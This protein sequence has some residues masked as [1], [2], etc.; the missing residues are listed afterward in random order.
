MVLVRRPR[1]S[2]LASFVVAFIG[3]AAFV[4]DAAPQISDSSAVT[5]KAALTA[6]KTPLTINKVAQPIVVDGDLSDL[7]WQGLSEVSTWYETNVG[8]NAV[9][10]VKNQAWLGFDEKFFYAAFRFEDPNPAGVRAPIGDHDAVSSSTDYAGIIVDSRNDGK[11]AQMF[12]ANLRGV[13]Y[14]AVSNDATGEDN[15]PDYYWD[16]KGKR[17]ATGWDL[18]IRVPFS[19][20][21]YSGTDAQTWRI[22]LYR[23]YP[24]DRRYQFFS[25]RLPKDSNCF[26]CN[27]APLEGLRDFPAGSH[28]IVAPFVTASQ[29]H[30]P[31]AGLGTGLEAEDLDPE[32][33]VDVKWNPAAT[34]AIDLTVNPDFSQL[35]SDVAQ[36]AANER[37]A[38]FFP[39]KRPFFLEGVDLFSTPQQAVYT[40]TITSPSGGLRGT[41]KVGNTAYTALVTQDQ[42]GGLVILPG[43]QSSDFALQDFESTVGVFRV[44]QDVGKSFVSALFTERKIDGGGHN[45]VVGPDFQWRPKQTDALTGQLLWSDSHTPNRPDLAAEWDGR[46]LSDHAARLDW[47]H[48]TRTL[49]WFLLGM[50]VGSDFRA[51]NGFIPQVGYQEALLDGGYTFRNPDG[52]VNRLRLFTVDWLDA[53]HDGD[54]LN[55]RVSAGLGANAK[56]NSFFRLELNNDDIRVGDELLHRFRPRTRLEMSPG[57]VVNF[58]FADAYFG[59]EIDFD[60][61]REGTGVSLTGGLSLRPTEHLELRF[62]GSRRWLDVDD[63]T[64]GAGRLFTAQVERLRTTYSFTALSFVRLIGQYVQTERDP[65]LYTFAVSEKTAAFDF[66]ALFAYKLNWQTVF[67]AGYGDRN[68]YLTTSD[69]LEPASRQFF[70]KASYA[71]QR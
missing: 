13:Q 3:S 18:E 17:T 4:G 12:L 65:S 43:P 50:D 19:S 62:D 48:Q 60:N 52:F 37:F 33:G 59:D 39:E 47:Y 69:E 5:P 14:D 31:S 21:R 45:L 51:D 32:I 61:A 20:L 8:D 29:A 26:I 58:L 49:D 56:L 11:T 71:W 41:G 24:R 67:F 46:N 36:I 7:G 6:P 1:P 55:R 22:M 66:S 23:N 44:R 34:A 28:L 15:A 63:P 27:S 30:A 54:P 68:E 38:L 35:E 70:M 9:P 25:T 2:C 64:L 53:E 10:M 57:R 40:R 42:G 16:A